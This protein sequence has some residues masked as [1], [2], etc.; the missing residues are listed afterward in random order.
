MRGLDAW[1]C[2]PAFDHC[3]NSKFYVPAT[4]AYRTSGSFDLFLQHCILPSFTPD[5]HTQEVYNKLFELIQKLTKPAKQK[6]IHKITKVLDTLAMLPNDSTQQN[7]E[8]DPSSEG[9]VNEKAFRL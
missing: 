7:S 2:G 6:L 5:Q 9:G 1:Y 3:H 8:G 4:K